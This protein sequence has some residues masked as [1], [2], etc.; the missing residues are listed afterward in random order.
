MAIAAGL[1]ER[2]VAR[3][4]AALELGQV[5]TQTLVRSTSELRR[6]ADVALTARRQRV[7]A[8]E[9]KRMHEM[10]RGPT[11]VVVAAPALQRVQVLLHLFVQRR[12]RHFV[13][14]S[15]TGEAVLGSQL[16]VGHLEVL[17]TFATWRARDIHEAEQ[18]SKEEPF[19]GKYRTEQ[20]DALVDGQCCAFPFRSAKK[21]VPVEATELGESGHSGKKSGV[22]WSATPSFQ[23]RM[24]VEK[25]EPPRGPF[26]SSLLEPLRNAR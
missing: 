20:N 9:Q 13:V 5:T 3:K 2:A 26:A 7:L 17:G 6:I 16:H 10:C 19:H 14:G 24:S 11:I 12:L 8:V 23:I 4:R 18:R 15:M 22:R 1:L 21:K 25:L